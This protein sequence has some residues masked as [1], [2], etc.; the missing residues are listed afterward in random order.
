VGQAREDFGDEGEHAVTVHEKIHA[1]YGGMTD[2]HHRYRSW[3]H[4]YRYFHRSTPEA[5]AVDRDHAA[6][7]LGF[8]LASWGMYRGSSFLLQH[9]YT[10]HL[11]VI[12]QLLAPQFSVLWK[13]EFGA[14]D[15]DSKLVPII[16]EA[17]DAVREAYRPFAPMAESRQASDTLV[18]KIILG[19]FGCLPACDRYF[20]D[21]FKSAN[22]RYSY[23]NAK[24]VERVLHFCR[25]NLR[26]LHEEQARIERTGGM[27]YPLMKLVDMYFWQIGSE[28][29]P[30]T[31]NVGAAPDSA[32]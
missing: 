23:L 6:L 5:I 32:S 11:G 16:L 29:E 3:E 10:V 21:G 25:D 28:L 30:S 27:W 2:A 19:T 15:N 31:I 9:T 1:Y 18:T 20:I 7:Q 14:G 12:D 4:C 22:F 13:L 26:E 8:Y 17:I 24:F